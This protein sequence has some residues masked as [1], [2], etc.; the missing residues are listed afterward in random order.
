LPKLDYAKLECKSCGEKSY[1]VEF[2]LTETKQPF[3]LD[4]DREP[5]WGY[6]EICDAETFNVN[7]IQCGKCGA[8][9]YQGET[10]HC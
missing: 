9:V 6:T 10:P 2:A 1:F 5:D 4:K 7:E 8:V 3:F